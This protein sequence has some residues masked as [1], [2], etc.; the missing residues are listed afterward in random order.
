[1]G[2]A[3]VEPD[4]RYRSWYVSGIFAFYQAGTA[5]AV[6]SAATLPIGSTVAATVGACGFA[7]GFAWA[8]PTS[9]ELRDGELTIRNPLRRH[10]VRIDDILLVEKRRVWIRGLDRAPGILMVDRRR[11]RVLAMAGGSDQRVDAAVDSLRRLVRP[12][13]SGAPSAE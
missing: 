1:M 8:A 6:L 2:D 12:G 7:V 13:A 10:V 9:V 4:W 11:I 3:D 5:G